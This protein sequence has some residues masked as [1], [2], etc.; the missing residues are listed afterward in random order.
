MTGS[1][2]RF[3]VAELQAF[4]QA[5]LLKAGL[6][7]D[8]AADV[9]DILIEGDL[10]G[11]ETHGLQLL[12]VYLEELASGG[13]TRVGEPEVLADHGA[14][15]TWDGK[16]LPG[17]WLVLRAI[18]V[19]GER[20]Q[21]FGMGA[22]SIRRSHHIAALAPYARRVADQGQVLLLMS[23][24]PSGSS[25]APFGGTQALF[26]P[27]P[28]GVGFPTGADPVMVDVSTSI[29]TNNMVNMLAREGRKLPG[30]WL[31]D[32][33]GVPTNDPAVV[34]PPRKGTL[35]PLGGLDAGH[36]GYGLSLMV[37]A[38]TAGLAGHGRADPGARWGAT[39]F[40]QVLDPQMFSGARQFTQ[41]M[42]WIAEQC[43][44]NVP[45]ASDKPVRLP[46]E[47]GLTLRREQLAQ[48][49]RLNAAIVNALA[50]WAERLQV[51]MPRSS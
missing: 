21:R 9:A 43:N 49:V 5:L 36:K 25:V 39:L 46:G 10:L 18:V 14:V 44:G 41:Q 15:V 22:V 16:R 20:A 7:A 17:P 34:K 31:L 42:D 50:P 4:A 37:E 26:S 51:E 24:A 35:L 47:R 23:S 27:S 38:L 40:I 13:M 8:K 33:A 32:E 1:P 28:I 45:V 19:A 29:T 30:A 6:S 11:H 2:D 12:P 48:G 3:D